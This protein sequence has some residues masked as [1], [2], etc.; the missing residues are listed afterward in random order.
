MNM[1]PKILSIGYSVPQKSYTQEEIWDALGY[2]NNHFKSIF[3]KSE[4]DKRHL[5]I[6]PNKIQHNT[7]QQMQDEYQKGAVRLSTESVGRCLKG[8]DVS[9]L[10]CIVYVSC[11]GYQCPSIAHRIT[12]TFNFPSNIFYTNILG[13]GCEGGYPGLIRARDA[14]L[15]SGKPSLLIVTELSTCTFFPEVGGKPNPLHDYEILRANAIFADASVA[16]LIGYDDDW[17]HPEVIDSEN[18]VDV[19]HIDELGYIWDSGRLRVRMDRKVPEWAGGLVKKAT[20]RLLK[21]WALEVEDIKWFVLH[22]AGV[23]VLDV[24]RDELGI[25]EEKMKLSRKI[26][27]TYG[28]CSSTT[29]GLVGKHLMEEN[30]QQGD[31]V[32]VASVGPGMSGGATLLRFPEVDK[33][34]KVE[35]KRRSY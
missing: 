31:W 16:A 35:E 27:R 12:P 26:L 24:F 25:P 28:N 7:W 10:G 30:I 1:K 22:A 19:T 3:M 8:H 9:N 11:T 21:R 20:G 2:T 18:E 5:W 14:T 15:A 33:V 6:N 17:R 29:I 13:M 34:D 32:L 4:I 23:K